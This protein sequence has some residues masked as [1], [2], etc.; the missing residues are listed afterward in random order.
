MPSTQFT[1]ADPAARK[2]DAITP[3]ALWRKLVPEPMAEM[4]H[5]TTA[6]TAAP[7]SSQIPVLVKNRF[8][9]RFLSAQQGDAE[10]HQH[11]AQQQHRQ[12]HHVEKVAVDALYQQRTLA[13]H[14]VGPRLLHGFAAGDVGPQLCL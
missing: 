8:I 4:M 12:P 3:N 6:I 13:L 14:A 2:G 5:S 11:P 7:P 10:L 9:D 1:T